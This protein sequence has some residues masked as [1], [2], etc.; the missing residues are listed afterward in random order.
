VILELENQDPEAVREF[1]IKYIPEHPQSEET[2]AQ[3]MMHRFK[4]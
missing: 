2:S 4:F 3:K 1:L